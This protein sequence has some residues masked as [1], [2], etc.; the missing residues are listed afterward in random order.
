MSHHHSGHEQHSHDHHDSGDE[1]T[2]MQK[3]AMLLEHWMKH[4][5]NHAQTYREWAHKAAALAMHDVRA[6]I[7]EAMELTLAANRKFEQA[8]KRVRE[9]G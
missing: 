7:E 4:N 6:R 1:L 8:L 2:S 3:L 5:E 9:E